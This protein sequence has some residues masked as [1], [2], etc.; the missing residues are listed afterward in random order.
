MTDPVLMSGKDDKKTKDPKNFLIMSISGLSG[1]IAWKMQNEGHHVIMHIDEESDKHVA[2]GFIEKTEKWE[3]YVD[4]ADVVIFDDVVG[5]EE[6]KKAKAMRKR[7]KYVIGGTPY[8]DRLEDDRGFGQEELKRHGVKIIPY[9]EFTSFPDAISFVRKNPDRYVL[10]PCGEI[11]NNKK[12]LFVGEEKDGNDVIHVLETYARIWKKE[13][14]LFQLQKRVYGVEVAVGAFFNG[15][16]FI[17]PINVNFEHKR[18]I[19]GDLG[20]MTGEMGTIMFWS[21]TNVIFR[22]TLLKME[23]TFRKEKYVGYLDINCIVNEN[24]IFPL[25]FSCRFGYPTIHIQNEGMLDPIGDFFFDLAQ[26]KKPVLRVKKGLQIGARIVVPPYP[27]KDDQKVFEAYAKDTKVTFL[28]PDYDGVCIEEVQL[29]NNE[30]LITGPYGVALLAVG[31]GLTMKDARE[32]LASRIRNIQIP[33]MYYRTDIGEKWADL[34][35][36]LLAWGYLS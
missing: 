29:K 13:M 17:A 9:R 2:D 3:K 10:K 16:E 35:D 34:S 36:K 21:E 12:L 26:G 4:W 24:G 6:G 33:N 19:T 1:N 30:W 7:G 32:N 20:P 27:Y 8:T 31:T 14:K 23:K 5:Q 25:E 22:N 11:Q 15:N 18:L 28:T